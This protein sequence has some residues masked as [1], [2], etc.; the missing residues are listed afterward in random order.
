MGDPKQFRKKY[1]TPMYPWIR[2]DIELYTTVRKE[3]GLKNRKEILIASSFLKKYKDMAKSLI[4]RKTKQGEKEKGQIMSKLQKLGLLPLN[5]ELDGIL[6]LKLPH[7]LDR[8]LQSLV[9]K[10][11]LARSVGQARQLIVHRHIRIGDKEITSPGYLV[12]LEEEGK[13][14]FK[15]SSSFVAETHPERVAMKEKKPEEEKKEKK[16]IVV[17]KEIKSKEEEEKEALLKV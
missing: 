4:A 7:V 3:Y 9:H 8:R 5:A 11:N 1:S 13:I 16:K 15:P 14:T 2:T 12:S 10:N 6:E 17:K